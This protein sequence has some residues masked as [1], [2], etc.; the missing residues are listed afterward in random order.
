MS[1]LA[2]IRRF[3]GEFFF[4]S[5]FAP[6][7]IFWEGIEF[8]TVEHAFQ[9]AK[10]LDMGERLWISQR[11]RPERAK[12]AGWNLRT[13]I[14]RRWKHRRVGIMCELVRLKFG[15]G[16]ALAGQLI[17]TEGRQL[18]EG[19]TWHDNFW[20]DCQCGRQP[21][22]A[23]PGQNM[24]GTALMVWREHLLVGAE[25]AARPRHESECQ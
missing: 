18:S 2:P 23:T 20:G 15:P 24:L 14:R 11:P 1:V 5:N 22:C 12:Q 16:S 4:L 8:P 13:P 10:S 25:T 6:S 21:R 7:P 3:D 9:A 19:N 17:G